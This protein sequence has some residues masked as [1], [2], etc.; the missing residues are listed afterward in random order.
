MTDART[1]FNVEITFIARVNA[2]DLQQAHDFARNIAEVF[3]EGK[4]G[5][6]EI[7]EAQT[8]DLASGLEIDEMY[9]EPDE[10]LDPRLPEFRDFDVLSVVVS[11]LDGGN[12]LGSSNGRKVL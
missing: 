5:L 4:Y 1:P 3:A 9:P 11:P 7:V 10:E 2:T 6:D 12:A 8:D